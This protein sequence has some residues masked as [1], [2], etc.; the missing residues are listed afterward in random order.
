[1]SERPPAYGGQA[2]LEGVMMRGHSTWAVAVRRPSS[3]IYVEV[4]PVSD[5]PERH[6]VWKRPVLRGVF[7]LADSLTVGLKA[8][9]ISGNQAV[10]E[11]E[12]LGPA[13]MG[14]S[15]GLALVFF[16]AVFIALP[17]WGLS[18]LDRRISSSL[19]SNLLEGVLRIGLFVG[20]L[21]A[22]ARLKDIRRVFAYHGAEHQTIAAYEAG[23]ALEP[24][25]AGKYSTLHVR[26]GTN[27]LLIVMVL[28]ILVYSFFGRPA[29]VW[30]IGSRI[31]AIPLIAGIAYEFLKLG[32]GRFGDTSIVRALMAPGLWM[33]KVTT[34]VPD[35]EQIE[36]AIRA[37]EAVLPEDERERVALLPSPVVHAGG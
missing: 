20:Y 10:G 4:R 23:V 27:L 16:C 25:T 34:R 22:I 29:L 18:L 12:Q 9:S 33:Q 17:N 2:V 30:R 36:V 32:A 19:V 37:L 35:R 14:V 15:L 11:Q 28:T 1:V 6:P 24:E 13:A 31:L 3:E 5:F 7:A 21:V 8:L 26:C